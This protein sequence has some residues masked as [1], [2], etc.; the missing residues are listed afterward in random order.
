MDIATVG[1]IHGEKIM[2][3]NTSEPWNFFESANA[4]N[5]PSTIVGIKV[6]A[7]KTIVLIKAS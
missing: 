3:F 2:N 6:P 7:V 1:V 5:N 4:S